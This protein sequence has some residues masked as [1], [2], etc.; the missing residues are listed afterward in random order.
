MTGP[1]WLGPENGGE[2]VNEAGCRRR[3]QC[4]AITVLA[5]MTW[6]TAACGSSPVASPDNSVS[7]TSH[8]WTGLGGQAREDALLEAAKKEDKLMVYSAFNDEQSMADAFMETYGLKVAV[9]NGNSESVLQRVAQETSGNKLG[10]DVIV[11]PA[12]D[13]ESLNDSGILTPYESEYR[14]DVS[15]L[16][17]GEDWTGIRRLAFVAGWNTEKVSAEEVPT[18][19]ADLTDPAWKGRMSMEMGDYDWYATLADHY[20]DEGMSEA[21]VDDLFQ[22]LVAN[23]EVT[24]GHTAQGE[25]LTA[26]KFDIALSL[27]SQTVDRA[28]LEGAPVSYGDGAPR[29]G[30]VVVRYDAGALMKGAENPATATLY[31]DF[32]LSE[33]GFEVDREIGSLPP[34]PSA[35]DPITGA[36]VVEQDVTALVERREELADKYDDLVNH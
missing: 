14:D 36:D 12:A 4:L 31:L 28:K 1:A 23:S 30:P 5:A 15:E 33:A 34:V 10:N 20:Q 13:L 24:K 19:Y 6:G 29:V 17:K 27:Y 35:D 11:L 16:G 32:Q 25:F 7:S 26:G 3:Y 2:Q 9:Y 22:G 21:K 18:D 8:P